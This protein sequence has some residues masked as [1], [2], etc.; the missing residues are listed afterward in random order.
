M[1]NYILRVVLL[2]SLCSTAF[3]GLAQST[4]A[5]SVAEQRLVQR[6]AAQMCTELT[7]ENQKKSIQNL[8]ET[9]AQQLFVRL[10]VRVATNDK[11]LAAKVKAA[12]PN[13]EAYGQQLGRKV[14]LVM[15]AQCP[16]SQSLLMRLGS[17]QLSKQQPL[18]PEEAAVLKPI[19][20]AIC[21]DLQPRV[22]ELKKM[23]VEQRMQELTKS[24]E[25]N[26]KAS[27]KEI[28]Q[29]Y[30]ADIFLDETRMKELGSKISIQMASECP[31][32]VV[33]FAELAT[34]K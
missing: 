22:A 27:A 23:S 13:A 33:L 28:A 18:G 30:G 15:I 7:K 29:Q 12:G 11:E 1:K 32:V 3:R 25:K 9:E 5:D 26:L 31:E 14:G 19:A 16:V 2:L 6:V 8:S 20:S 34:K 24:F 21:R 10:F 17:A 4:P